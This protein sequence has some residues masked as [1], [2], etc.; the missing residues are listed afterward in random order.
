MKKN[1]MK[2]YAALLSAVL[3]SLPGCKTASTPL[4]G[5][6][7]NNLTGGNDAV[8]SRLSTEAAVA[9]AQGKTEEALRLYEKLYTNPDSIPLAS[10]HYRNRD[11]ALNYAQL[12]RKTGNTHRALEVLSPIAETRRGELKDDAEPIVLNEM[13]AIYIDLGNFEAA[14]PLLKRV[15][16]DKKAQAF[17]ADAYNLHAV[18]LD[19]RGRHKEAEK[20]FRYALSQWKGDSSSVMN[21]LSICLASQGKFDESLATLRQALVMSPNKQEIAQNI[22]IVT[23]LRDTVL[24]K[25]R[26]LTKPPAEAVK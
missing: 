8:E 16:K 19:A 18:S 7:V 4:V 3:L 6:A 14:E 25:P 21:N 17:H 2:F 5:T 23:E 22:Q 9:V 15:I 26:A 10:R 13:A 20:S 11:V 24:S 12:L 1:N